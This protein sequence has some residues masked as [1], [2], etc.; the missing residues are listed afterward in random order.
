MRL[1]RDTGSVVAHRAVYHQRKDLAEY[2]KALA[3]EPCLHHYPTRGCLVVCCRL[4]NDCRQ[5]L[6]KLLVVPG[7]L[8]IRLV[9]YTRCSWAVVA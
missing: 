4:Q 7:I 2:R 5:D 1:G 3:A 8:A 9:N 6:E